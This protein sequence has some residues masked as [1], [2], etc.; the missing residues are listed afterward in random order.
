MP[1]CQP[2]CISSRHY[3]SPDQWCHPAGRVVSNVIMWYLGVMRCKRVLGLM[4]WFQCIVSL[5]P[6]LKCLLQNERVVLVNS[7]GGREGR[8]GYIDSQFWRETLADMS[9]KE[10]EGDCSSNYW[11]CTSMVMSTLT[12]AAWGCRRYSLSNEDVGG[13]TMADVIWG[14]MIDEGND[15]NDFRPWEERVGVYIGMGNYLSAGGHWESNAIS[16]VHFE[17]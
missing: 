17:M 9:L 3:V 1:L 11:C 12:M 14:A 4:P 2:S 6:S 8:W 16:C 13:E 5:L 15:C 10:V 7:K